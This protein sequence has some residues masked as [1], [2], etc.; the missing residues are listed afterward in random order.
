MFGVFR[1]IFNICVYI[2]YKSI[3]KNIYVIHGVWWK[4]CSILQRAAFKGGLWNIIMVILGTPRMTSLFDSLFLT[5][6]NL[7]ASVAS[8]PAAIGRRGLK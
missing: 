8:D 6:G 4:L 1:Y 2:N 7:F 5:N 3:Q